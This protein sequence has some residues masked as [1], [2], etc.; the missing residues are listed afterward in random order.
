MVGFTLPSMPA[1]STPALASRLRITVL[2]LSRRLR[3]QAAGEVTASQLSA[4]SSVAKHGELTL[5][6]LA[7]IE[8]IAPPTMTRIVA[9]IEEH[10]WLERSTDASDR[11]LVR[12]AISPAGQ[13]LLDETRS[14]RDAFMTQRLQR[15]SPSERELLERAAPLLERLAAEEDDRA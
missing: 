11:R 9:R 1:G 15:L 13:S 4:L 5:G 3:Q 10:G 12:V 6:E 14:R 2:R 7:A 8:H